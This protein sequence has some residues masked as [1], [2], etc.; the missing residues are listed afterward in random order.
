M[1]EWRHFIKLN[2]E[3]RIRGLALKKALQ[4]R[5]LHVYFQYWIAVTRVKMSVQQNVEMKL[6]IRVFRSWRNYSH[7]HHFLRQMQSHVS[8]HVN[9]RILEHAFMNMRLKAEYCTSLTEIAEE[10]LHNREQATMRAVIV[11]WKD[12]LN[13]VLASRCY[14]NILVIRVVRRWEKFIHRKQTEREHEKEN[15]DKAI[16]L[17]NMFLC[18]KAILALKEEMAVVHQVKK[19]KQL[20]CDRYAK[21]WKN[22]VD[23]SVTA[24]CLEQE[25]VQKRAWMKWRL[26]LAKVKSI[27]QI[28]RKF[29][30]HTLSQVFKAWKK[31]CTPRMF[32]IP[33]LAV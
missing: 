28:T 32:Q 21:I 19:K 27:N 33:N 3:R 30:H 10:V 15:W 2:R 1:T 4:E 22:K 17:H 12:R 11:L 7:K 25:F 31:L 9:L 23:L 16:K 20:I 18:R 26:Q 24:V 6:L 13:A 14:K 8:H 29:D 5:S